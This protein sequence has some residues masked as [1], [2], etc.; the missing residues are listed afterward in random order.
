MRSLRPYPHEHV[1][2]ASYFEEFTQH[3]E[4]GRFPDPNADLIP[5]LTTARFVAMAAREV[6]EVEFANRIDEVRH[7]VFE[8]LDRF[9]VAAVLI[10]GGRSEGFDIDK[11][12]ALVAEAGF[13]DA[14]APEDNPETFLTENLSERELTF[15]DYPAPP[16][17]VIESAESRGRD[18]VND[19]AAELVESVPEQHRLYVGHRL[20]IEAVVLGTRGMAADVYEEV[21]EG[22]H[23][24]SL[25]NR[26]YENADEYAEVVAFNAALAAEAMLES[27]GELTT[28]P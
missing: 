27:N 26:R 20:T 3:I 21:I 16:L 28:P 17:H 13:S 6:G 9:E 7:P 18:K 14:D 11:F 15:F 19:S 8:P 22:I 24:E 10:D 5:E 23:A 1:G 25:S 2:N 4:S 12:D